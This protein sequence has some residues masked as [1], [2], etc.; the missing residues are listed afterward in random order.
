MIKAVI[1]SHTDNH[2]ENHKTLLLKEFAVHI[3]LLVESCVKGRIMVEK[4][5]AAKIMPEKVQNTLLCIPT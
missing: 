5:N 2:I 4:T 3:Q 1:T